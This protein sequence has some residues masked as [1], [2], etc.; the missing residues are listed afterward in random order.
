MNYKLKTSRGQ[1]AIGF[2]DIYE[3]EYSKNAICIINYLPIFKDSLLQNISLTILFEG[4][5][6]DWTEGEINE[7]MNDM[8]EFV[9]K[10]E[11][12]KFRYGQKMNYLNTQLFYIANINGFELLNHGDFSFR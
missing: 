5:K 1:D 9:L 12:E 10:N 4:I 11:N 7:I 2:L 8:S 6:E 3:L